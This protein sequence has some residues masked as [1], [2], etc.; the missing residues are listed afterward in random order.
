MD[1]VVVLIT[2]S[3]LMPDTKISILEN[4]GEHDDKKTVANILQDLMNSSNDA[5]FRE[6]KKTFVNSIIMEVKVKNPPEDFT[7]ALHIKPTVDIVSY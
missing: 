5:E 2:D 1:M 3:T 4:N 7:L 6:V